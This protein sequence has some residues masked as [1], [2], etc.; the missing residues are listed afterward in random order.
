MKIISSV[1]LM[2]LFLQCSSSTD[3]EKTSEA[4]KQKN[5]TIITTDGEIDDVDS[6]IRMLLYANEF[7]IEGLIYSSSMW[8]YKGDGKGT[9]FTSEMEM[10]Q[11]IYN[12]PRTDLRWPGSSWM[13]ELLDAYEKVQPNLSLHADGFPTAENLRKLVKVGN[14]DF[15]GE[16]KQITEGSEWIKNKL[17]D[18]NDAPI[19]LQA[20]GGTNTIARALK[21]IEEEYEGSDKWEAI[22]QKVSDKAIIYTIMDQDATFKKYVAKH[23]PDIQVLYNS[24]QFWALAYNWQKVLPEDTKPLFEGKFMSEHIIHNHGPLLEMYYSYGDGQK[25]EGD[26]EHIHGDPSKLKNGQWGSFEKY[27]FISEGD[28]P[29]Y[30]HLIDVGLDNI[31]H[32]NYGGWGGRLIQNSATP[33]KWDD[34]SLEEFNPSTGKNDPI[35]AQL[36]WLKALQNDL[37]ARAD[38]CLKRVAEANHAPVIKAETDRNKKVIPGEEVRLTVSSIDPDK[39]E[40]AVKFWQY[41]EAGSSKAKV[42]LKSDGKNV[43]VAIPS[44]V[45]SGET[46]HIIAEAT[47]NGSPMLTRY[48][49]FVL[50]V[51]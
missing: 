45:K 15:E 25:Q 21:S 50:T 20:W 6:F 40:V 5:R 31:D 48:Q 26:E 19:Y 34:A 17:L 46:I 9:L 44:D 29:A 8:H 49:R 22:R 27:D 37:A 33:S 14:I 10:T 24:K 43:L 16:M 7:E 39:D 4:S 11:K 1:F 47:D 30:L 23:W 3:T 28:S 2:L 36:R 42:D 38:W 18:D 51:Q 32:P 12:K 41:A 35:Y 13:N